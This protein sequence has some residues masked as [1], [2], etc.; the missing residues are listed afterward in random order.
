M[1]EKIVHKKLMT[2]LET[3]KLLTNFQFGYRKNKSTITSVGSLTDDILSDRN[4]GINTIATVFDL[5][6]A[7]DTVNHLIF[8]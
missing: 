8:I 3:N 2:F 7:F 6:K 5:K 4:V 1:L